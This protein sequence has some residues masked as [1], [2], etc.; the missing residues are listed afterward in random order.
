MEELDDLVNDLDYESL[1]N[2]YGNLVDLLGK[3][4]D[5]SEIEVVAHK[6]LQ[7]PMII[8]DES[9]KVITYS[10]IDEISDPIWM[11]IVSNEYCP[12]SI[13]EMT[14]YN[15]FWGR[16]SSAGSPLFVDSQDFSPYVRRAVAQI[17]SAGKVRGYIALVEINKPITKSDLQILQMV[18]GVVG[19]KLMEKDAISKALGQMES[20]FIG[21]LFSGFMTNEKMAINRAKSLR[22]NTKRWFSVISI[23]AGEN[24]LYIGTKLDTIK[25][26]LNVYFPFCIYNFNGQN[27]CFIV[28]FDNREKW[29]KFCR[30]EIEKFMG[31]ENLIS[32][33]G[34]PVDK[35]ID[36]KD[37]YIQAQKAAEAV[38]FLNKS[39]WRKAVY[40]Y[41][42]VA[43]YNLLGEVSEKENMLSNSLLLLKKIDEKEGS[44]YVTTLKHFFE[45][46]QNAADTAKSMY[47]HRNTI[48]YRLNKI[49]E[50]LEDDFNNPLVRLHLHMSLMMDDIMQK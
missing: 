4:L 34:L 20:E 32:T 1:F 30:K 39:I 19:I 40:I 17:K 12:S 29:S 6:I 8:T 25:N 3:N 26:T 31:E 9:Y 43:V 41:S 18:A 10:H 13:V 23:Q 16:L 7:N 50:L 11:T 22:W 24:N 48:N 45:N 2:I 36:I 46:N 5:I 38:E 42:E 37:S 15:D 49:R 28:S 44:E 35:L 14:D 33:V 21:D 27:A 47:L